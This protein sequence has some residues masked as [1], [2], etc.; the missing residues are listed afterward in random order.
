MSVKMHI[1]QIREGGSLIE[2]C[3]NGGKTRDTMEFTLQAFARPAAPIGL[4]V[5]AIIAK[6]L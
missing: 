6:R 4:Q 1:H 3:R 2:C 5:C